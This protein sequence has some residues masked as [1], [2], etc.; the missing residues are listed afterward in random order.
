MLLLVILTLLTLTSAATCPI[1]PT[2]QAGCPIW[3]HSNITSARFDVTQSQA[4][5][6]SPSR[7]EPLIAL[8]NNV[9]VYFEAGGNLSVYDS[10]GTPFSTFLPAPLHDST[11]SVYR[12][13]WQTDGNLVIYIDGVAVWQA[14][15]GGRDNLPIPPVAYQNNSNILQ[16]ISEA[17]PKSFHEDPPGIEDLFVLV[18][19]VGEE[20][21]DRCSSPA[22]DH[23][24]GEDFSI[25]TAH[26]R[27]K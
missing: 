25:F 12:L 4:F 18:I 19:L 6:A 9:N 2:N 17:L 5:T 1:N 13:Q 22:E 10:T 11:N 26:D 21:A 27:E 23:N 15:T 16:A 14:G 8:S 20:S 3:L 24:C 7:T